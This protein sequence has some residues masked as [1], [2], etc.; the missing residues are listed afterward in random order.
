MIIEILDEQICFSGDYSNV[1]NEVNKFSECLLRAVFLE[2][3][4]VNGE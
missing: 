3:K 4:N 1:N 2:P